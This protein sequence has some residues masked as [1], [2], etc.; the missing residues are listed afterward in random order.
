M[1]VLS[2]KLSEQIL[3]ES[4]GERI[5]LTIVRVAGK[6]VR[7]GIEAPQ[8]FSIRRPEAQP[9]ETHVR[10]HTPKRKGKA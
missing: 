3:V 6:V 8:H 4:E 7:I 1:L 5:V 9:A 2:R 10:P